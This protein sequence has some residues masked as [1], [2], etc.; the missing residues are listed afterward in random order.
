M[1]IYPIGLTCLSSSYILAMW[2]HFYIWPSLS[3]LQHPELKPLALETFFVYWIISFCAAISNARHVNLKVSLYESM[4]HIYF[5]VLLYSKCGL[6]WWILVFLR[7]G[8]QSICERG[9][10]SS[11][12]CSKAYAWKTTSHSRAGGGQF[13][14]VQNP[15]NIFT[16]FSAPFF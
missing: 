16:Y 3:T 12:R 2:G 9:L 14:N 4:N 15:K 13:A 8:L 6:H 10:T 7:Q 11:L 5:N 1:F